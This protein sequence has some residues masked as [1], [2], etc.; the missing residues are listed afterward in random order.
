MGLFDKRSAAEKAFDKA[1][2]SAYGK[3]SEKNFKELE[4]AIQAWP[5]GWRG[6]FYMGIAY[7]IGSGVEYDEEKGRLYREKAL[8]AAD[9]AAA[10]EP[11]AKEYLNNFYYYYD[12]GADCR[13]AEPKFFPQT[14]KVRQ[15]IVAF[16]ITFVSIYGSNQAVLSRK[17]PK[18]DVEIWDKLIRKIPVPLFGGSEVQKQ[19]RPQ[20][21]PFYEWVYAMSERLVSNTNYTFKELSIRI[22]YLSE[23]IKSGSGTFKSTAYDSDMYLFILGYS[24]YMATPF[25]EPSD[26]SRIALGTSMLVGGAKIFSGPCLYFLTSLAINKTFNEEIYYGTHKWSIGNHRDAL[27][28]FAKETG[29]LYAT[30][31]LKEFDNA[32][33]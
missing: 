16:I 11:I 21:A 12:Q 32:L 28:R 15:A 5:T 30:V 17:S 20:T 25:V 19:I 26:I 27:L 2:S 23:E 24:E 13:M 1:L 18:A 4:G 3:P 33:E 8:E 6:Y 31:I 29:D 14:L 22:R 7:D 9:M 10:S